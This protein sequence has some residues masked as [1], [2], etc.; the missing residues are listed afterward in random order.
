MSGEVRS[1]GFA[2]K[3]DGAFLTN[4]HSG[5]AR[6]WTSDRADALIFHCRQAAEDWRDAHGIVPP[7][8]SGARVVELFEEV[9]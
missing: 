8:Y 1:I 7:V 9:R 4:A 2:I 3:W 6:V 5:R